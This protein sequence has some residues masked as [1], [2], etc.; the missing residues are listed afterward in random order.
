MVKVKIMPCLDM[1]DGRVVKGVHFVNI[2]DA[3]D[4]VENA[5]FYEKEGADELAMLDIAAT[6]EGRK[7]RLQWV[8]NVLQAITLPLTVGGGISSIDD[9]V[10]LFDLGVS[11]ISINT[12]AVKNPEIIK[13]ASEK[14]GKEKIK[15]SMIVKKASKELKYEKRLG[16][17]GLIFYYGTYSVVDFGLCE[18]NMDPAA[19]KLFGEV[20]FEAEKLV[21]SPREEII[22]DEKRRGLDKTHPFV[23]KLLKEVN[24]RIGKVVEK[25]REESEYGFSSSKKKKVLRECATILGK[26]Y[27]KCT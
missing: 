3:G 27:Q 17:R 22:V 25:E 2:R 20:K 4:P 9:M 21:R 1:K 7:T 10:E 15:V 11:K 16:E 26:M 23:Q 24:E 8:K 5:K 19:R 18:Y 12:S 13:E 14:F 6:L